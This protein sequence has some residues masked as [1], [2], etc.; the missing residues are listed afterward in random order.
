METIEKLLQLHGYETSD[1]IHQ[2]YVER[3][4]YQSQMVDSPY[5]LLT[6][7]CAFNGGNLDVSVRHNAINATMLSND[8]EVQLKNK[9][10]QKIFFNTKQIEIMNARNI[11]PMD[12]NS[13]CDPFVRI[14]LV[15][16]DKFIATNRVKTNVQSKTLFPLFDEKFVM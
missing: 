13:S 14:Y 10:K 2:Y 9:I 5:G 16:E 7:K 6:I 4:H 12:G 11:L 15:P 1:L 3:H 8:L